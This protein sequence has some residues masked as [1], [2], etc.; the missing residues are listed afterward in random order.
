MQKTGFSGKKQ[1]K[2]HQRRKNRVNSASSVPKPKT[3]RDD[4]RSALSCCAQARGKRIPRRTFGKSRIQ[5]F[6]GTARFAK[7]YLDFCASIFIVQY[8]FFSP[9]LSIGKERS[10]QIYFEKREKPE[11]NS[12]SAVK[13]V[14][15]AEFV[16]NAG[17]R[18]G[19]TGK[20]FSNICYVH[21]KLFDGHQKVSITSGF[22]RQACSRRRVR[23]E[24]REEERKHRQIF[25][26]YLLCSL[27]AF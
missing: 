10:K 5:P 25:F 16:A 1:K 4:S 15:D 17:K 6:A 23:C 19:N 13:P 7:A 20:F 9:F 8:I 18:N 11:E 26:L 2:H 21:L 22:S 24:C 12:V 27:A 14:A 3:T